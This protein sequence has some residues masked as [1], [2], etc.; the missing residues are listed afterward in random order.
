[1]L[2]APDEI[3]PGGGTA[4][5]PPTAPASPAAVDPAASQAASAAPR[6]TVD[7]LPPAALAARL[8]AAKEQARREALAELGIEDPAKFKTD[9]EE[10][11]KKLAEYERAQDEQKR[12]S[13]TEVDRLKADLTAKDARI[14]E[15][16]SQL[17]SAHSEAQSTR[18]DVVVQRTIGDHVD[19]SM[20]DFAADALRRHLKTLPKDQLKKFGEEETRAF[21]A[22]LVK[23]KPRLGREAAAPAAPKAP[24]PRRP[25]TN[26]AAPKDATPPGPAKAPNGAKP[27]SE[28]TKAEI[29]AKWAKFGAR[30]PG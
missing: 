26:G 1:M 28:L 23:D 24:P 11:E 13:M 19:P 18:F 17:R 27:A 15:L 21:F 12:A 4:A 10:K 2:L 8:R 5:V 6:T 3:A 7:Q 16:E 22:K 25:L 14:A 20:Q 30:A 9:R 29:A